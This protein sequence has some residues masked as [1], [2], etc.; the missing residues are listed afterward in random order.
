MPYENKGLIFQCEKK[1]PRTFWL[2]IRKL[3]GFLVKS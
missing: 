2:R 1:K 3:S